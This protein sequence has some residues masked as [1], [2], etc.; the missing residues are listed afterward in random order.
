MNSISSVVGSQ[1]SPSPTWTCMMPRWRLPLSM[2]VPRYRFFSINQI[3]S[4]RLNNDTP[5]PKLNVRL[6]MY[7]VPNGSSST[8]SP[9]ISFATKSGPS[10]SLILSTRLDSLLN[11][12]RISSGTRSSIIG[13][14]EFIGTG[15][16]S[17]L[18][19]L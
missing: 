2:S 13:S 5:S 15:V 16:S 11:S 9:L 3:G 4:T 10:C 18:S 17:M 1:L 19:Y 7:I 6:G 8:R 14:C 12:L